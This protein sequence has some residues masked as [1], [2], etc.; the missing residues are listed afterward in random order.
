M[1]KVLLV[2]CLTLV[3]F[4][5]AQKVQYGVK[6]GLNL[7]SLYGADYQDHEYN[8]YYHIGGMAELP[9]TEKFSV[10]PELLYSVQGS[11]G[12]LI[13]ISLHNMAVPYPG[14]ISPKVT[15]DIKSQY[16]NIPVMAKYDVFK[17]VDLEFGPQLGFLLA[18]EQKTKYSGDTGTTIL[19]ED[20][21]D[22]MNKVDFGL[23]FGL[24]YTIGNAINLGARYN[25]GLSKV[26]DTN[27]FE[28]EKNSVF[29]FSVGYFF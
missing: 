5:Y 28:E 17:G 8:T 3:C 14:Y 7:A 9:I 13:L 23:N 11:K 25:L 21:K 1:K 10:Q 6:G 4:S 27:Y 22:D 18:A 16:L 19:T 12:D 26:Y 2:A 29:Q 15:F 20:I 24:S